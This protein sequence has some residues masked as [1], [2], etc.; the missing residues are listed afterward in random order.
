MDLAMRSDACQP[1]RLE[2]GAYLFGALDAS[3]R[4]RIAAHLDSCPD[5]RDELAG[6]APL[7][8]LLAR[9]PDEDLVTETPDRPGNAELLLGDIA[10]M[11]RRRRLVAAG[12]AAACVAVAGGVVGA[13][14]ILSGSRGPSGVVIAGANA[15]SHV[16]GRATLLATPEGTTVEVGVTGVRPGT[17]CQLVVLGLDGRREVA[18]TWRA[19]YEGTA[20]VTGASALTPGQ[21]RE[22]IVAAQPGT[23]LVVMVRVRRPGG[24]SSA[25]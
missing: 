4:A 21:I 6:L 12:L 20:T 11:R 17:R 23:P 13:H 1:M 2:L 3:E 5:C 8:G 9:I 16:S 15:S 14:D 22:L 18:A 10:R 19:N 24:T 7:P 25:T